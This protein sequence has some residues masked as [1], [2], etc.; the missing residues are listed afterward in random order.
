[1]NG[2]TE[3]MLVADLAQGKTAVETLPDQVYR[4]FLGGFGL[5][6]HLAWTRIP[7]GTDPLGAKNVVA[8]V[9]GLLTG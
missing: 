7:K 6:A 4:L 9:P 3:K 1:M 2:V 8:M 5:G